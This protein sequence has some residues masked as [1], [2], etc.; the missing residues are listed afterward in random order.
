MRR[1][2]ARIVVGLVVFASAAALG[3]SLT[4][5]IAGDSLRLQ[6]E[7]RLTDL[8]GSPVTIGDAQLTL[9]FGFRLVGNDVLVWRNPDRAPSLQIDRIRAIL[10][11]RKNKGEPA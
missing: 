8:I 1:A 10:D 6:A 5:R 2:L 9:G 7:S 4:Q 3:F 11:G